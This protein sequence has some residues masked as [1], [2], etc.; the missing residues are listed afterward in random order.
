LLL[1]QFETT[2][3]SIGFAL[4]GMWALYALFQF[5]SGVLA[6]K[7][8]ERSLLVLALSATALGTIFVTLTPSLPLFGIAV[9]LLGAGTGLFFAPASAL[10]SRLY[11]NEGRA[12]GI[13]T[14]SGA[15]AGVVC[16]A[17]GGYVG[18]RAGWQFALAFGVLATLVALLAVVVLVP[19]AEPVDTDQ[20]L[21]VLFDFGRHWE[22]LTRSSIAYSVVLGVCV[23]FTFQAISSFLPTFLVEYHEIGTDVAGVVFGLIFALSAVAQPVAGHVS[24][25]YSRDMAIGISVSLALVGLSVLLVWPTTMGLVVGVGLLGIG[26]SWP[27]PIQARFF[28]RLAEDERGYGFGLLRTVYMLLASAGSA[29]V[30]VLADSSGWLVGFGSVLCVLAATLLILGIN[31]QFS[32]EL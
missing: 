22:L 6:D 29:V 26:V 16:P 10:V 20:S 8:G 25:R 2:R 30:G 4:T 18:T 13:L 31:W 11:A 32:L 17:V 27:G 21:D 28:D 12:L 7:F 9:L 24:D 19:S 5:P 14:A 3:S 23:G 1:V 15:V